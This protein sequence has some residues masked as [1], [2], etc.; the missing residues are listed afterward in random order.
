MTFILIIIIVLVVVLATRIVSV[1]KSHQYVIEKLG[2]YKTIWNPGFHFRM[3][4]ETLRNKVP[5][6]EMSITIQP[7]PIITKD[8]VVITA[9]SFMCY[10][11][12]DPRLCTYSI[13][14][15]SAS[16]NALC[17][18]TLRDIVGQMELEQCL[19]NRN[20]ISEEM[21]K[22]LDQAADKW[23]IKVNHFEIKSFTPK[24]DI[25]AEVER[26]MKANRK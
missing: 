18:S 12:Y 24:S 3:P 4:F 25:K 6:H 9:D 21:T 20:T 23:G 5:M 19:S 15:V 17:I 10:N 8:S 26:Q 14:D 13:G 7:R 16:L 22:A 11:I 2:H 1:P